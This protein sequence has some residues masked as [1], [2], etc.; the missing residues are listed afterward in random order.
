MLV[1]DDDDAWPPKPLSQDGTACCCCCCCC[2]CDRGG[3]GDAGVGSSSCCGG[4]EGEGTAMPAVRVNGFDT[5]VCICALAA[6]PAPPKR[7][8]LEWTAG[9]SFFQMCAASAVMAATSAGG[10]GGGGCWG[11]P[12]LGVVV[13]GA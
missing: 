5:G 8:R 12:V 7:P 1:E 11:W 10:D 13:V 2:D 9:Q 4:G 3:D 6:P